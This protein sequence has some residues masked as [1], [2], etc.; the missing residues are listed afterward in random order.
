MTSNL[1]K[2][3][4]LAQQ[5]YVIYQKGQEAVQT[6]DYKLLL[7]EIEKLIDLCNDLDPKPQNNIKQQ[8]TTEINNT[9]TDITTEIV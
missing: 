1:P 9:T 4:N 6:K 8:N 2:I 3:M 5:I 7:T